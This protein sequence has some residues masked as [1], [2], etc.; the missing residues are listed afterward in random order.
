MR[1]RS[2]RLLTAGVML[3]LASTACAASD[4][5]GGSATGGTAESGSS[6]SAAVKAA[7]AAEATEYRKAP[8]SWPGPT[9]NLKPIDGTSMVI[10]CGN[11]VPVCAENAE[12]AVSAFDALKWNAGTAQDGQVQPQVQAGLVDK[13]VQADVD[14]IVLISIDVNTIQASIKRAAEA[15][16]FV[17]CVMCLSGPQWKGKVYDV[18]VDWQLQGRISAVGL[19]SER[20]S[21]LKAAIFAD[22]AYPTTTN[23]AIGFEEKVKS[24]CKACTTEVVPFNAPDITKPGPPPFNALLA[25]NPKGSNKLTDVVGEYGDFGVTIA[26]TARQAGRT[27]VNISAF[28][29]SPG[30]IAILQ[31]QEPPYV[32]TVAE[33]YTFAGWAAADL[34]A[35]HKAGVALWEG[36][37]SLGSVLIDQTNVDQFAD[38]YPVPDGDWRTTF[39]NSKWNAA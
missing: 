34:S 25:A 21:D 17:A 24:A 37:D 4:T 31:S 39:F 28:D 10:S 23:R 32:Q 19:L 38:G 8:T 14:S 5:G 20:G 33:P 7:A 13:A 30:E 27:D 18:T 11:V 1:S 3:S 29:G 6:D 22:E 12:E 2:F 9:E 26:K 36:Y 15:G 35:R 16:V